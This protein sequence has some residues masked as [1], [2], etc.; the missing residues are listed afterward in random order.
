MNQ[1]WLTHNKKG[2]F[3]QPPPQ[4][5]K[6][7]QIFISQ[8]LRINFSIQISPFNL[9]CMFYA[10]HTLLPEI[11]CLYYAAKFLP[12]RCKFRLGLGLLS[13]SREK[14]FKVIYV[15]D[16]SWL[17]ISIKKRKGKIKAK[18]S[19]NHSFSAFYL[20]SILKGLSL[21][22]VCT[23]IYFVSTMPSYWLHHKVLITMYADNKSKPGWLN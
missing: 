23:Q 17:V 19:L 20:Q 21:I 4:K 5:K 11:C 8:F 7:S 18:L 22:I 15:L 1:P 6:T 2:Q 3:N 14:V 13:F 12:F 16:W 10:A 9:W